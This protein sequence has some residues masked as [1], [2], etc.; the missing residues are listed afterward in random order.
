M[1]VR[2]GLV[3]VFVVI[4]EYGFGMRFEKGRGRPE[5]AAPVAT[6]CDTGGQR[7]F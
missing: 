3:V 7:M 4:L 2:C 5:V 6:G 1:R